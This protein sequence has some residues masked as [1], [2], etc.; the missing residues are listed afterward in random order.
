MFERS[1]GPFLRQKKIRAC[2]LLDLPY[3]QT[4]NVCFFSEINKNWEGLRNNEGVLFFV[5]FGV[6][7]FFSHFLLFIS[8]CSG[9]H[10]A[11]R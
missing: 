3:K 4:R 2:V 6:L 10:R 5:V 9:Q 7:V 8:V 11:G 1:P